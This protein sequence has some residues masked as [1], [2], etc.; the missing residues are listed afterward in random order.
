MTSWGVYDTNVR[1][2]EHSRNFVRSLHF[3]LLE[4]QIIGVYWFGQE[5]LNFPNH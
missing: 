1:V 5:M 4:H 3:H 2:L